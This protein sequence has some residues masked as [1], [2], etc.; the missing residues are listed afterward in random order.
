MY[1]TFRLLYVRCRGHCPCIDNKIERETTTTTRERW[2]VG[3][4]FSF[5]HVLSISLLLS[6]SSFFYSTECGVRCM[7]MF[8]VMRYGLRC[9]IC[10]IYQPFIDFI[11]SHSILPSVGIS[12]YVSVYAQTARNQNTLCACRFA[13][14]HF[15]SLPPPPP[16]QRSPSADHRTGTVCT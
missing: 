8:N 1:T 10:N 16:P 13:G 6:S 5:A 4:L 7:F 3:S 9:F 12:A 2:K 14:K 11:Y 15:S